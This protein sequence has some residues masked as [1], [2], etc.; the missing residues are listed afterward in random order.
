[1]IGFILS[2]MGR[3]IGGALLILAIIGS[4]YLKG[5]NAGEHNAI[6]SINATN[7]LAKKD[8][9]EAADNVHDCYARGGVWKL[10]S[11]ECIRP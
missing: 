5:R 10:K 11:R 4:V 3:Y 1:M 7:A 6:E 8:A 2:P 9:L